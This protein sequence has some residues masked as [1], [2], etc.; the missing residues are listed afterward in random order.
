MATA[1]TFTGQ[2]LLLTLDGVVC[3]AV[4]AVD[5]GG[6]AASLVEVKEG[7]DTGPARKVIGSFDFEPLTV[8]VGLTLGHDLYD[9]I[10][11]TLSGTFARK[12]CSI[13]AAD[14][15]LNAKSE[16]QCRNSLLTGVTFGAFDAASKDAVRLSLTIEP[17]TVQDVPASGKA[18]PVGAAPKQKQALAS[19]FRLELDGV[20]CTGVRRID[21]FAVQLQVADKVAARV[22]FPNL[23]VTLADNAAA[24]SWRAWATDFI[25]DGD[26][27]AGREKSGAIVL[28]APDLKTELGRVQLH[29]VGICGLQRSK[30]SADA[31]AI[32]TLV[33]DLFCQGMTVAIG[34][35]APVPAPPAP[36]PAPPKKPVLDPQH[37]VTPLRG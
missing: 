3:G 31:D 37:P 2:T 16:Q 1:R 11:A 19:N 7:G 8:D 36:A 15:Q 22:D 5:G 33:A 34:A 13:T 20:D 26:R 6:I 4:A 18:A 30:R 25:V 24:A 10:A 28:L 23:R 32:P 35:P 9:W 17:E 14:A 27:T 29:G 12:D 21:P